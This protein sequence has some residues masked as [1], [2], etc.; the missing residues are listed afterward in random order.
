MSVRRL[1]VVLK[2]AARRDVRS[3]W[4]YSSQQ[5]GS[6]QSDAYGAEISQAIATLSANPRIG[7]ARTEIRVGLRS[8]SVEQH[9]IFYRLEDET[10]TILRI[11][12]RK[13]NPAQFLESF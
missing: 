3:I 6:A 4:L 8:Y 2:P 11:L 10:V 12:H 1:P 13:M 9:V 7:R 5:W